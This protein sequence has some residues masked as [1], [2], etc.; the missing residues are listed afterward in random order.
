MDQFTNV[1]G[2]YKKLNTFLLLNKMNSKIP[3]EKEF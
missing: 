2:R 1:Q 3:E